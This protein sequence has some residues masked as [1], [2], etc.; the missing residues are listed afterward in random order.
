MK[1][2]HGEP[3]RS[4][5]GP[6]SF[7]NDLLS[8]DMTGGFHSRTYILEDRT[9]KPHARKRLSL[10]LAATCLAAPQVASCCRFVMRYNMLSQ[11]LPAQLAVSA[12][13]G[14]PGGQGSGDRS[15]AFP[16]CSEPP[17][18]TFGAQQAATAGAPRRGSTPLLNLSCRYGSICSVLNQ[19]CKQQVQN[20]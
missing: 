3:Q 13:R 12:S 14:R 16:A 6:I 17:A 1:L 20:C 8:A 4:T 2:L 7:Q 18:V 15:E 19:R 11:Q 9:E 5:L 10:V